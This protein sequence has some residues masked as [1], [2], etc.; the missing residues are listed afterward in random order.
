LRSLLA[1]LRTALK[2]CIERR[3]ERDA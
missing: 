3:R 2:Q 1:R